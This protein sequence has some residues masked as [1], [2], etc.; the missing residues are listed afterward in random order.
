MS[1]NSTEQPDISIILPVFN[2][3]RFLERS[4]GSVLQQTFTRWELLAVDDASTDESGERLE[5][6]AQRDP[7]IRA[8]R[9][10]VNQ[11]PSAARN[12]A[13]RHARGAWVAYLDQDDEYYPDHLANVHARAAEGDVLVFAYDLLEERPGA[14]GFGKMATW[15]PGTVQA[16]LLEQHIACPLAVAHR[17]DLLDRAG[18][19]DETWYLVE[20]DSD[21]WRRLHRAGARFRF[22]PL[23]SG[24]Y[25]IHTGS[26]ARVRGMPEAAR[27]SIPVDASKQPRSFA[28]RHCNLPDW[29]V[30]PSCWPENTAPATSS[31]S[32][33][34][35]RLL[36]CSYHS[37][38]DPSSGAALATRDLLEL[39]TARGWPCQVFCGPHLDYEEG[40]SFAQL[41]TD[42]LLPYEERPGAAGPVPFTLYHFT[43]AGVPVTTYTGPL[44]RQHQEPT[45]EEGYAFLAL[46]E[47]MLDRFQP[48][49][50]LTYGGHWVNQAV[51]ACARSRRLPVVFAL[52]NFAYQDARLF[53]AV[54]AVFVPSQCAA[55][56]YRQSL[57]LTCTVLP[58]PWNWERAV[59][60]QIE[61]K[62]VTFI[63]PQPHKGV[64]VF[65]R[66]ATEL[67]RRRPDIP[68]LIVEGRGKAEWL[69]RTGHDLTGLRN[70][71]VMANTPDP[72]DFYRVSRAVLMPS[73]WRESLP[74]VAIESLINGIPILASS[75]GGL[76]EALAEAGLLFEVPPQYTPDSRLVP[77]AEEVAP[78]V[79]AIIRLW[80]DP[81]F[82]EQERQRCRVA[83]EPWRSER[84]VP[85]FEDF[86]NRV[87]EACNRR[88]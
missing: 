9:L 81:A 41:L 58:G 71:H 25:H 63:N 47:Q 68:L 87:L 51:L 35:P 72:R 43:Q 27:Q 33:G 46:F 82:L 34:K 1:W 74:R 42:H 7:R 37:Y 30:S 4:I 65:A 78:W 32:G 24:I 36:F 73:L 60:S 19:F 76:P 53:R 86:F 23:K 2:G 77:T 5:D 40:E 62:Y 10:P 80:D 16:A 39:L 38:L 88:G 6:F 29:E 20:E 44:T 28:G 55:D 14:A 57:G 3:S 61:G 18:L 15:N 52:H 66:I 48:D 11:G 31:L 26:R 70:L 56:H 49:L 85:R 13:L 12:H 83:A 45:R 64:F 69:W 8:F 84:L 17:R 21:M 50:L 79:E 59:C 54:D 22:L 67:G 75:R